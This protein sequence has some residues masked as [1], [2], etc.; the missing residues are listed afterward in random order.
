MQLSYDVVVDKPMQSMWDY[1]ND[2]DNLIHWLNDFV[3]Y[4][5]VRGEGSGPAVGDTANVTYTQPGGGEFTMTEEVVECDAPR[6]IKLLM[7]SKSFDMEILNDFEEV[8]G[9]KTRLTASADFIRLGLMMKAIFFFSSKKKM[10]ADHKRQ[11]DKLKE[12]IEAS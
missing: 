11:I 4:E 1:T 6:H 8:E 2:P 9:G 3:R 10:L 12:L 7:T 5:R